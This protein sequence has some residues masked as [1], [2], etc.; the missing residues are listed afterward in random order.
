MQEDKHLKELLMKYGVE[1]PSAGFTG[2]VMQ[3]IHPVPVSKARTSFLL[4]QL[5]PKVLLGAFVLVCMALLAFCLAT[6]LTLPVQLTIYLPSKYLTQGFSFLI[7][8]WVAM[9]FNLLSK[10]LAVK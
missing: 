10:R 4:E 5:L 3:H 2:R 1:H 6:P 8:F 9:L 7:A